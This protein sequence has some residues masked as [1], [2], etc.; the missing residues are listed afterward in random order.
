MADTK[1]EAYCHPETFQ[2]KTGLLV[3]PRT[4]IARADVDIVL[5]SHVFLFVL[6]VHTDDVLAAD[7]SFHVGHRRHRQK[8]E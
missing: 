3:D 6:A 1:K 7:D 5:F 4:G 2:E 8:I